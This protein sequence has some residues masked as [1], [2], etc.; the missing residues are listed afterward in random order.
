MHDSYWIVTI[1]IREHNPER[2]PYTREAL[3]NSM[4]EILDLIEIKL[5]L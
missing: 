4:L 3:G 2:V 5:S 1:E